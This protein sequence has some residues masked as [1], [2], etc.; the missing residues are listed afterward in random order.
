[1]SSRLAQLA[2]LDALQVSLALALGAPASEHLRAS[3]QAI[4]SR[5]G[6]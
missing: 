1:M 3:K 6:D 2:L 4:R 5:I